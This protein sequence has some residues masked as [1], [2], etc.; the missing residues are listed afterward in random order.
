MACGP[1][2]FFLLF[3]FFWLFIFVLLLFGPIL[4]YKKNNEIFF[5]NFFVIPLTVYIRST[6]ASLCATSYYLPRAYNAP[7][8]RALVE[9]SH[10][11][12]KGL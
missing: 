2:V 8:G 9:P 4:K 12:R 6:D 10:A 7:L 5:K 1:L 3:F 11:K